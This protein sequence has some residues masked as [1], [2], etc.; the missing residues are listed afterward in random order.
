M[1]IFPNVHAS[2]TDVIR[3]G[4]IGCGNRGT[5]AC[6]EALLAGANVTLVAMGDLFE[7]RLEKSLDNLAKYED[8]E[9]QIDVTPDRK[10]IGFDAY[11]DV[12]R[13]DCDAVILATPPHFR[14][15]HYA[16]A[17]AADKHVF[18]EKPLCVD[19]TGYRSLVETNQ[20]AI[21]KRRSVV[22]GLQRRHQQ[23][24]L[25][26]VDRIHSGELG[27]VRLAQVYFNVQNGSRAGWQK[28]EGMNE[29]EYQLRHWAVFRWLSGDF[30]VEQTCHEIDVANWVFGQHPER[31][32][33]MGDRQV[34]FGPGNGDIWDRFAVEYAYPNGERMYAQGRQ[35]QGCWD[36]VSDRF[37]GTQGTLTIGT[38]PWGYG[39]ATPRDLKTRAAKAQKSKPFVNPYQQE[40]R[41]WIASI[42]GDGTYRMEGSYGAQSSMTAVMG[43]MAAYS[44][45]EISWEDAIADTTHEAPS[46]YRWDALAPVQPDA[47]GCYA[48]PRQ[49]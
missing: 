1:S 28:P 24:Y 48:S 22:A 42:T 27:D 5:G 3:L 25:E 8:T 39:S 49:G 20:L 44:G 35:M 11:L 14:P 33:G 40:H 37:T 16:A 12:L 29:L 36:H 19:A 18:M 43:R 2:G 23:N 34:R 32:W 38:G 13:C 15:I 41:D 46:E 30:F 7:E 31:A 47:M 4:F 17:I 6:R 45:R 9:L 26:G 21:D 10:F